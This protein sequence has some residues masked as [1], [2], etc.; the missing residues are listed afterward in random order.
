MPVAATPEQNVLSL[1]HTIDVL[2]FT[3]HAVLRA[4]TV[5]RRFAPH[6]DIFLEGAPSAELVQIV[7]GRVKLWRSSEDGAI[8]A[9]LLLGR[10]ELLGP[11][12][13]L[14]DVP[15]LASATALDEVTALAWPADTFRDALR[16]DP[17]FAQS[18]L[19][20]VA[21][22]AVQLMDRLDDLH[23]AS[24]EHRLAR[25]LLRLSG[26]YGRHDDDLSVVLDLRQQELAEL[27]Q[28]T[29]PT[30]SRSLGAWRDAGLIETR[31][32]QIIIPHL[33]RLA[34]LAGVHVD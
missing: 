20:T 5:E 19:H 22:R 14:Q 29:V 6:E 34:H 17:V 11:V 12:A 26:D 23:G 21:R 33:S 31:R 25:L 8:C 2:G 3:D 18:F 15:Q 16:A 32:G 28:T 7:H 13:I 10:G 27:A 30:V 1:D 9:L 24:V 4:A